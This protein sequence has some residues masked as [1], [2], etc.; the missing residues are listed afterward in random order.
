MLGE[1]R[2][3]SWLDCPRQLCDIVSFPRRSS[4]SILQTTITSPTFLAWFSLCSGHPPMTK[5]VHTKRI[6]NSLSRHSQK[7]PARL[8][9]RSWPR[10][11]ARKYFNISC[12]S[13]WLS[14]GSF[15]R[16]QRHFK[17]IRT[18][19]ENIG[20]YCWHLHTLVVN[21]SFLQISLN[22]RKSYRSQMENKIC[23]EILLS[24]LL[25]VN[26]NWWK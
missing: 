12:T 26:V 18:A 23:L 24:V 19:F 6:N 25:G 11:N 16:L 7:Q 4:R 22:K 3:C 2:G 9:A 13:S 21:L 5:R 15:D 1:R 10:S 20:I 14:Y 17:C 8:S